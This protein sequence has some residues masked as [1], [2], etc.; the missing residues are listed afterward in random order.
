MQVLCSHWWEHEAFAAVGKSDGGDD[1]LVID[2][3]VAPVTDDET[4]GGPVAGG[5]ELINA[6]TA[7]VPDVPPSGDV[8]GVQGDAPVPASSDMLSTGGGRCGARGI[9]KIT[10]RRFLDVLDATLKLKN[11]SATAARSIELTI[12]TVSMSLVIRSPWQT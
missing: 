8:P 2:D 1:S 10:I 6:D 11:A 9:A 12:V 7:L 3:L 5:G 4:E